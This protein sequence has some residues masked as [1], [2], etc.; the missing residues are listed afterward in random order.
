MRRG[1]EEFTYAFSSASATP[2]TLPDTPSPSPDCQ[3]SVKARQ[4][5]AH[6]NLGTARLF[7]MLNPSNAVKHRAVTYRLRET[8]S[9]A[10]GRKR[11]CTLD[12]GKVRYAGTA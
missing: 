8:E 3:G 10:W 7:L 4:D 11:L 6:P 2:V 12:F 9:R 5:I 1:S